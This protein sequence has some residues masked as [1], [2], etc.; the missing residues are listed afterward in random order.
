MNYYHVTGLNNL[1]TNNLIYG[2]LPTDYAH[3]SVTCT[4]SPISGNDA[5]GTNSGPG[6]GGGCPSNNPKSDAS[7]AATFTNFQFDGNTS[8]APSYSALNYQLKTSPASI[9]RKNKNLLLGEIVR[10]FGYG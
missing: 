4:I 2:N 3:H 6:T 9:Y 5:N 8:P 10:P 7:T 1:T